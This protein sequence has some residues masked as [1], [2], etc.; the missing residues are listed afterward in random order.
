MSSSKS[1]WPRPSKTPSAS[2]PPRSRTGRKLVIG[3]ILRHHPSWM[4]F[5]EIARTLGTPLSSA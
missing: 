1:R 3:Y 4:K 5:I 2:S